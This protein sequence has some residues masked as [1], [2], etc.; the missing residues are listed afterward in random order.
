MADIQWCAPRAATRAWHVRARARRLARQGAGA[1]R[2]AAGTGHGPD[3]FA[4]AFDFK[5]RVW[6]LEREDRAHWAPGPDSPWQV[7]KVWV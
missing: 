5:S 7:K 3:R 2:V 6:K 1:R 4:F